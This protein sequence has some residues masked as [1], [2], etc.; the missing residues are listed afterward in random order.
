MKNKKVLALWLALMTLGFGITS[1]SGAAILHPGY[2]TGTLNVTN[3][4]GTEL[5]IGGD[6]DAYSL[7]DD[8]DGH[9]EDLPSGNY[10]VTVEGDYEYKVFAEAWIKA[11]FPSYWYRS[12]VAIGRQ[13]TLVA[14]GQTVD[15]F[16]FELDPGRIA[17]IVTVTNGDIQS[18]RFRVRTD[19]EL[20]PL[21]IEAATHNV[22]AKS[23]YFLTGDESTFPMRPWVSYDANA[24]GDYN[25]EGES[26]VLVD[27][28]VWVDGIQY[29]L[30]PQYV[31]VY[32]LQTTVVEWSLDFSSS[33]WGDVVFEGENQ[34]TNYILYANAWI[35]GN[36]VNVIHHISPTSLGH[37]INLLPG[38]WYV[39]AYAYFRY[40]LNH[41]NILKLP[42]ISKTLGI[43]DRQEVSW[44]IDPAYV[45]GSVDLFGAHGNL[46]GIRI[47]ASGGYAIANTAGSDYELILHEGEWSI[48]Q[49]YQDLYFSYDDPDLSSNIFMVRYGGYQ[50]S[51]E[52][53]T[54]VNDID[55]SYDTATITVKYRVELPDGELGELRSPHLIATSDEGEGA[56]RIVSTAKGWGSDE[57]TTLGECTITVFPGTHIIGAYATVEGSYTKFGEFSV[58]VEPGDVVEQDIEAP[59][60]DVIQPGGSEHICGS[61]VAVVGTTTDD[62]GV[63]SI[64]VNGVEVEFTSTGNPDDLNEVS[65]ST[66]VD[67]LV[68][69]EWNIITIVVT[70]TLGNSI[71][72]ERQVYRDPC[73]LPPEI[74][75]IDGPMDPVAQGT[76][77]VMTGT[78]TDPDIDDT[79]TAIW[80]WGDGTTSAGT[81]DQT[82]RTVG[83]SHLYETPGVYTVTLTVIDS[84]GESDTV[85]WSPYCV[86]Y[87][88]SAGFV[89]GGGWIDSPP[90][91]FPEDPT[92]TGTANFGFVAKYKKGTDIPT[93]STEFQFQVGNLNFHSDT[94]DWLVVAGTKAK[95]K[96]T[97]TI[98]GEGSYKFIVTIVDGKLIGDGAPDTFR[99]KIWT[100]D[101]VTGEEFVIYDNGPD[102]TVLGGGN[103]VIHTK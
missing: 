64:T 100:E 76:D 3:L 5:L 1:V 44:Y 71:T 4:V 17:P 24:D 48:G 85:T 49:Y 51:V 21:D 79:H 43:E 82:E 42:T 28:W 15:N 36:L 57:L 102:G 58:T 94:Y 75:S 12:E 11:D 80:D 87:D 89:T 23:G 90:G 97:G 16:N 70:D 67:N 83:G 46:D 45:R 19:F 47:Y 63:A 18:M 9:D 62:S 50:I 77:F 39:Y 95:F 74:I 34:P 41:Y 98:N 96:G 2:I 103:I 7:T 8:F 84:F 101:E 27:G 81:V 53:G 37:D 65:F 55:F 73:N 66:T 32:A 92:L 40:G 78:F 33:I 99:I 59:A 29:H 52:P 56:N 72:V 93:G 22:Y 26:Y 38:D 31:D 20:P 86:I 30:T 54:E 25:D 91:A 35:D 60:V 61:S 13:D 88:P 68:V 14:V 10:F 69:N 6:V